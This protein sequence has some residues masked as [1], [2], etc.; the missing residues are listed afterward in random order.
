MSRCFHYTSVLLGG[1][2]A[3]AS[4]RRRL[5]STGLLCF[6]MSCQMEMLGPSGAWLGRLQLYSLLCGLTLVRSCGPRLGHPAAPETQIPLHQ[7]SRQPG[8]T[9]DRRRDAPSVPSPPGDL[10][11]AELYLLLVDPTT[12]QIHIRIRMGMRRGRLL[13]LS[14]TTA[15][16]HSPPHRHTPHSSRLQ[17]QQTRPALLSCPQHV[18]SAHVPILSSMQAAG[19]CRS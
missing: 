11:A 2:V 3:V 7:T 4:R 17:V 10:T 14:H 13:T 12:W 9:P 8:R 16:C 6:V 5:A 1:A 18:H 19:P 15:N